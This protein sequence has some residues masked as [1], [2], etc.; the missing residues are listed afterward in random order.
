[1]VNRLFRI[2]YILLDREVVT[3]G[4]LADELEVTTRT[5]Y[6]DIDKLSLAGIP[7]Y[8]N[9]G[10]GGGISLLPDYVLD[11]TVLGKGEKEKILS[12][13][14]AFYAVGY[15]SEDETIEKLKDFL[16][17]NQDDWIEIDFS[18]WSDGEK[19]AKR[20]ADIKDAIITHRKVK[21]CYVTQK[22][23]LERVIR[24]LKLCFKGQAWY[25]YAYCETRSDYRFFK[26]SRIVRYEILDERFLCA[27]VGKVL[28]DNFSEK[29]DKKVRVKIAAHKSIAFRLY[30]DIP[31]TFEE[32]GDT[33]VGEIE[34]SDVNWFL[35]YILSYGDAFEILEPEK[36][37]EK[38]RDNLTRILK[39][40]T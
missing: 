13:L 33:L 21:I 27:A 39:K 14:Q 2:V 30:D 36:V 18:H 25:V 37:R 9:R 20:F 6:R 4:Q 15:D 32:V 7:I 12:S 17:T 8:T 11:K 38:I 28:A 16:G 26:L 1:M 5:I 31:T 35:G 10:K 23:N 29:N 19:D 34:V 24:P 3:A 40:Y 22:C